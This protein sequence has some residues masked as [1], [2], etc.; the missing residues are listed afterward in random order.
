MWKR[1]SLFQIYTIQAHTFGQRIWVKPW[2]Y[3][4]IFWVH[5]YSTTL[6]EK[7]FFY[8]PIFNCMSSLTSFELYNYIYFYNFHV[9][10]LASQI[11]EIVNLFGR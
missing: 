3:W 4:G 5:I 1:F 8:Q 6:G 11:S 9:D 10:G 7:W 2:C